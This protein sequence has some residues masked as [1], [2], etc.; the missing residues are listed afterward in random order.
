MKFLQIRC[1]SLLFLGCLIGLAGLAS[2]Y[3][4]WWIFK[5]LF[6]CSSLYLNPY[7]NS[8]FDFV[9]SQHISK[10]SICTILLIIISL[11]LSVESLNI[12][13]IVML[14]KMR[15][16]LDGMSNISFFKNIG[17]YYIF[18]PEFTLYLLKFFLK[19]YIQL[20]YILIF[21]IGSN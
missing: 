13:L 3:F 14:I 12:V 19:Y 15:E 7:I 4:A 9:M 8:R 17:F 20:C 1:Y 10:T 21:N 18:Y 5:P 2:I 16:S 11:L 6:F